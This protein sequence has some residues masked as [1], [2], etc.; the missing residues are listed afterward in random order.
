MGTPPAHLFTESQSTIITQHK[1]ILLKD[2]I[3]NEKTISKAFCSEYF[4]EFIVG[5]EKF[6][7]PEKDSEKAIDDQVLD[8]LKEIKYYRDQLFEVYK[9]II[10][11]T[12]DFSYYEIL[13]DFFERLLR[14]NFPP[15]NLGSYSEWW[16]ENYKFFNME[17]FLFFINLLL[18]FKKID[19]VKFFTE[20]KYYNK[21]GYDRGNYDFSVFNSYIKTLDEYRKSRLK[22]NRISITADLIKERSDLPSLSFDE[23]MQA[24]F[25]LALKSVLDK[26]GGFDY[27]FPRTLVYKGWHSSEPFPI[28]IKAESKRFFE[29]IAKLF[30]INNRDELV[31]KFNKANEVYNLKNWR[32]D[33]SSIPFEKFMNLEKLYK[34]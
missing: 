3:L 21:S 1:F 31:I 6:R 4:D 7:L 29:V 19:E 33:Y 32:F 2:S 9:L 34:A 27:W 26:D 8:S 20:E 14:L 15:P 30:N 11:G 10:T 17:N 5:M 24:D 18:K 25:I 28:F 23:L 12:N 16:Y 13:F 22:M